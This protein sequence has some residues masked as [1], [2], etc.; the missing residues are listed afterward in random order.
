MHYEIYIDVVFLTN[1]LMDYILL[2][3]IGM[4]FRCGKSRLRMLFGAVV[5]AAFSCCI[6]C[7]HSE[8]FLPALILL[9]G[10]CAA[11][12]LVVGCGLKKGSLLLKAVL[13][14]YLAAFLCGGLWEVADVRNLTIQIFILLGIGTWLF[15]T[16]WSCLADSLRI[17]MRS[18]YPV[19]LS[20]RGKN[21]TYYGFY[22]S[23]NLLM[24][25]V[26]Q[27]PVSIGNQEILYE[28]LPQETAE[29]LRN[30]RER[31]EKLYD[32]EISG[33]QP[34]LIPFQSIGRKQGVILAVTLEKLCIQTPSE[35][36]QIENPVFA[37]DFGTSAFGKEYEILLNSRLL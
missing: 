18:I 26:N 27:K 9:H 5:G 32:R 2:R 15:L 36:V 7:I 16:A 31:P 33:L 35:V 14:L 17:Q 22:D 10:G 13:T 29:Q 19:T 20:Y 24:D 37:F 1:L 34:H 30:L 25:P 28:I 11:G 6:L 8:I 23:G 12:M 4:I 21:Y 3:V